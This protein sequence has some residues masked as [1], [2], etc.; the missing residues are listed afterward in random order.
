VGDSIVPKITMNGVTYESVDAMPPNVRQVYDRIMENFPETA[1]RDGDGIPDILQGQ[2]P[3]AR[4]II[5]RK[6][7][8]D[9]VPYD[10]GKTMPP[11]VRQT[12]ETAMRAVRWDNP[13]V[14]TNDIKLSFDLS[15]PAVSFRKGCAAPSALVPMD[16]RPK[17]ASRPQVVRRG[18][19]ARPI[20]PGS[21]SGGLGLALLLA[22][23][24]L[25][26]LLIWALTSTR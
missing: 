11:S 20:E 10:D 8:V 18:S 26:S 15:G 23:A 3:L 25:A 16:A 17:P 5:R 22:A 7:M 1:D 4:T 2:G 24:A 13:A 12:H 9:G 14:E 19:G 21:S 6:F